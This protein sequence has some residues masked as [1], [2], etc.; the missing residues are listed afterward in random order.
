MR[1]ETTNHQIFF[2]SGKRT[3]VNFSTRVRGLRLGSLEQAAVYDQ[4]TDTGIN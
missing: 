3:S 4:K 2:D 1:G